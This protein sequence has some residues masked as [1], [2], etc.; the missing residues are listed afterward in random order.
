MKKIEYRMDDEARKANGAARP[1]F[2]PSRRVVMRAGGA[3]LLGTSGG[4]ATAYVA[5][6]ILPQYLPAACR[7]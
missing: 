5:P 6:G 2:C 3:A 4:T 7:A 1:A